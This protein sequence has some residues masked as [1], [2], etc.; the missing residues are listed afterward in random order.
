MHQTLERK[1]ERKKSAVEERTIGIEERSD[2][3]QRE[4]ESATHKPGALAKT[5]RPYESTTS[6]ESPWRA[7]KKKDDGV[8][9]TLDHFSKP[10]PLDIDTFL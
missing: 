2:T 3:A 8:K 10:T 4:R 1:K 6:V 9:N 5:Q 7:M